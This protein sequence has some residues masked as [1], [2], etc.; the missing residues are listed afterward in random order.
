MTDSKKESMN[1]NIE[2]SKRLEKPEV[3]EV[4][5]PAGRKRASSKKDDIPRVE[6]EIVEGQT[7]LI[8][9]QSD[10]DC[11]RLVEKQIS[12]LSSATAYI[13]KE[14]ESVAKSFCKIG[15]K[16]WEVKE[17]ELFKAQGFKN[18]SEYGEKVLGFKKS[19]TANYIAICERFSV[20]K[21][22][23]PTAQLMAGF[24]SF[25]YGQLSVMLALPED[26]VKEVTPDKTCKE[27]REMK[28][29]SSEESESAE[30]S[31][32]PEDYEAHPPI[33]VFS[34]TLTKENM[35]L[36]ISLLRE[37]IGKEISIYVETY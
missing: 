24:S 32:L 4:K 10:D 6:A 23:K 1:V 21:D 3:Q 7:S 28:K 5:K 22:E 37:N 35:A 31:G 36:V 9:K 16:L 15:F 13:G 20:H 17:K 26:K 8:P 19:S 11:Q 18:I 33:E 2:V 34:R 12:Q 30:M 25:S 29:D 27:I 14:V